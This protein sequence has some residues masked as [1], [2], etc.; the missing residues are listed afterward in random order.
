[1]NF[2]QV[3]EQDDVLLDLKYCER[4]GGLWLRP[5]K[6]DES[7]CAGCRAALAG[8]FQMGS[9]KQRLNHRGHR[10]ARGNAVHSETCEASVLVMKTLLGVAEVAASGCE[11]RQLSDLPEVSV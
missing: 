7:Y 9:K 6:N 4:C 3:I 8:H 2:T 1:M 10:G 5:L 11:L